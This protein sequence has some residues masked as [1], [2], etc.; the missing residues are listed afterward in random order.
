MLT[1]DPLCH[2]CRVPEDIQ[3]NDPSEFPGQNSRNCPLPLVG[4]GGLGYPKVTLS[5]SST[6]SVKAFTT[7]CGYVD[8]CSFILT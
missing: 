3:G 5:T 2:Q 8:I 1:K 7:V 6:H 4:A